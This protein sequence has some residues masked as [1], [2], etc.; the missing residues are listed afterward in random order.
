MLRM[1]ELEDRQVY[2]LQSRNLVVGVWNQETSGFIGIREKFGDEYLFTEYHWDF[3]T[4]YGTA[5]PLE[6]IDGLVVPEEVALKESMD[7]LCEAHDLAM[8]FDRSPGALQGVWS[9]IVDGAECGSPYT[10]T[11]QQLM[12]FLRESTDAAREESP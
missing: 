5:R 6:K 2:R 4:T 7:P 1:E 11:N 10:R 12:A 3:S 8:K 9:H